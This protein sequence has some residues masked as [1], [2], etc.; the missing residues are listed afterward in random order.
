MAGLV[1]ANEIFTA[2]Y[3]SKTLF[4]LKDWLWKGLD[5]TTSKYFTNSLLKYLCDSI[6]FLSSPP[7]WLLG[8]DDLSLVP[9][10]LSLSLSLCSWCVFCIHVPIWMA[11]KQYNC[12]NWIFKTG[13]NM[14][15]LGRWIYYFRWKM[16]YDLW[17]VVIG[18]YL[19]EDNCSEL[20]MPNSRVL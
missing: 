9:P 1:L 5:W 2:K 18:F 8:W 3:S 6:F 17:P 16:F 15:G 20:A 4:I 19:A 12:Y 11:A 10:S 7:L 14:L 13:P